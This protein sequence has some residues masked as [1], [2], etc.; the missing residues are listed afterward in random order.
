MKKVAEDTWAPSWAGGRSTRPHIPSP[1]GTGW[2]HRW[3]RTRQSLPWG[4]FRVICALGVQGIPAPN[5]EHSKIPYRGVARTQT[6]K[7][8]EGL[9]HIP[10]LQRR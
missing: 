10:A 1:P 8:L 9:R 3:G 2:G 7:G 6:P 4:P 5:N